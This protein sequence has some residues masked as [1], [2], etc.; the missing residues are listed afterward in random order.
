VSDDAELIRLDDA[1]GGPLYEMARNHFWHED[2]CVHGSLF[3]SA[4]FFGA[5]CNVGGDG[6]LIEDVLQIIGKRRV[7]DAPLATNW[8]TATFLLSTVSFVA[9]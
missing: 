9:D 5:C 2:G 3:S 8:C 7:R 1:V 6:S 4:V